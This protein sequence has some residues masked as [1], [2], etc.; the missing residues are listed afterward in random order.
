MCASFVHLLTLT[1]LSLAWCHEHD[2]CNLLQLS[3]RKLRSNSTTKDRPLNILFV[4]NSFTYGPPPYDRADQ[5]SLNNVPRLFK[6]IAESLGHQVN[7]AEDTIGGCTL[8][9][10]RPSINPQGPCH[11][12]NCRLIDMPRVPSTEE[13]TIDSR[14]GPLNP[15]YA[16]CPQKFERQEFGP[17]DVVVVQDMSI[18]PTIKDARESMFFPSV[19]EYADALK[20][21]AVESGTEPLIATYMTWAYY[22]GSPEKCPG[23]SKQGCFPLGTLDELS[24][25]QDGDWFNKTNS[26]ACQTYALARGYA[27]S[28]HHGADVLVPAGLAWQVARGSEPLPQ[29]CKEAVDS[30]YSDAGPLAS[31]ELP[32]KAKDETHA[33]WKGDA[34]LKLFRDLGPSYQSKYCKGSHIDHHASEL[35]MYLNALV[36]FAT[37]FN[38]SPIGAAVPSGTDVVD[39]MTL[40]AVD[41]IAAKALQHVA[42]DVVLGNMETW[43]NSRRNGKFGV[44]V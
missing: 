13:C 31:L 27:E 40:P 1:L 3:K 5:Q 41:P 34:A 14:I 18:L 28:L 26:V 36:F 4:G 20:R 19:A 29:E 39:G 11:R 44:K 15:S 22:G 2:E 38:Q 25:C 43:W 24:H 33:M 9:M 32:L 35:G 37:L 8:W 16:P 10:H 6:F 12:D 30:E 17:W 7:Q 42:H 23:E 21:L